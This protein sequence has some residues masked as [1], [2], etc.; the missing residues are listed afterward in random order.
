M[1]NGVT[2]SVNVNALGVALSPSAAMGMTY[3]SMAD[4]I[5]LMMANAVANQQGMQAI[6]NAAVVQVVAMILVKGAQ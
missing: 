2:A 3:V 4:S 5:G 1:P 6:T